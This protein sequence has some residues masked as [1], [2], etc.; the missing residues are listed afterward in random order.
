VPD[1]TPAMYFGTVEHATMPRLLLLI[2]FLSCSAGPAS[3]QFLTPATR[4]LHA[5]ASLGPGIGVQAGLALPALTIFTQEVTMYAHYRFGAREDQ[6]LLVGLGVGGSIRV[7]RIL[8]ILFDY[9]PGPIE[10]DAGLRF[11][12]SFAFSFIEETAATKA[13]QFRLFADLF[14][15]GTIEFRER[16]LFFAELGTQPGWLRGGIVFAL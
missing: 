1:R 10:L 12:P 16:N 14:V 3:S 2:L 5:G 13:R 6:Y 4:F 11:G 15:R 8:F 9:A 7:L